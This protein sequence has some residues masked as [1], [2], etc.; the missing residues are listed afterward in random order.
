MNRPRESAYRTAEFIEAAV[1][2]S[3]YCFAGN[4]PVLVLWQDILGEWMTSAELCPAE[5]LGLVVEC[6][7]ARRIATYNALTNALNLNLNRL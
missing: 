7:C 5:T 6:E 3:R 2:V 1:L 4:R